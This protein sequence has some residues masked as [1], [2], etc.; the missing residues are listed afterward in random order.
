MVQDPSSNIHPSVEPN[1][2]KLEENV[3]LESNLKV[4]TKEA[5]ARAPSAPPYIQV[6]IEI[7]VRVVTTLGRFG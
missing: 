4:P 2:P 6:P 3:R 1:L 7:E 5:P